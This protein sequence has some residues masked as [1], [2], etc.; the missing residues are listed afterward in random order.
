MRE[1]YDT[2]KPYKVLPYEGIEYSVCCDYDHIS[3]Y[4]GMRTVVHSP[5]TQSERFISHETMNPFFSKVEVEFYE[6]PLNEEHRLDLI[7]EKKLGSSTYSWIIAYFNN[8]EDGYSCYEGQIL[9]I[10]KSLYSL[11]N[12]GEILQPVS[13]FAL[14]LST[15]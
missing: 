2:L 13:P 6:V 9:A 5:Q 7:A 8:I 10:P 11:F 14:N 3:R 12:E 15:E 4:R 1:F